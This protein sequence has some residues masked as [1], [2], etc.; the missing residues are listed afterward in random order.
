MHPTTLL[1][2]T[3]YVET[4]APLWSRSF[5]TE[6]VEPHLQN[7]DRGDLRFSLSCAKVQGKLAETVSHSLSLHGPGNSSFF[8]HAHEYTVHHISWCWCTNAGFG[9]DF[10]WP[11][12]A[13][14]PENKVAVI[15]DT[16]VMRPNHILGP[17]P[18]SKVSMRFKAL[19]C[20]SNCDNTDL[21]KTYLACIAEAQIVVILFCMPFT[22][23]C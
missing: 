23:K 17:S 14:Y 11:Y 5:W 9:L 8:K 3:T 20:S 7:I 21:C 10:V 12:L 22:G 13:D 6:Y 16:C 4:S 1:R 18:L 19:C 15:D 2:H